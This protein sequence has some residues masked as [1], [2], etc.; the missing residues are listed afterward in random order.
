MELIEEENGNCQ[1]VDLAF[2]LERGKLIHS[3]RFSEC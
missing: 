2:Y 1:A 3:Y